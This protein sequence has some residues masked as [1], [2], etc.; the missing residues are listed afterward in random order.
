MLS[1]QSHLL[2]IRY[3]ELDDISDKEAASF[4]SA[5]ADDD[6]DGEVIEQKTS[7]GF[8]PATVVIAIT[9]AIM[10]VAQAAIV[11]RKALD[12]WKVGGI[13]DLRESPPV[14]SPMPEIRRG[15]LVVIDANGSRTENAGDGIADAAAKLIGS[16]A[17][18]ATAG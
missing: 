10:A 13:L 16:A 8:E 17:G 15:Q 7:R 4:L 1:D 6:I 2:V 18:G 12:S 11:I 5:L 9:V 3:D 14:F